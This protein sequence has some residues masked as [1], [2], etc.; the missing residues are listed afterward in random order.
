MV[1]FFGETEIEP[2]SPGTEMEAQEEEEEEEECEE[3]ISYEELKKRMWKDRLLLQKMQEKR[4]NEDPDHLSEARQEA[5]RRKKMSR[6][7]DAILKYMVKIMEVCKGKGFVY[8]IVPEKGKPI[9]GSSDSLRKWWK[10][11]VHFDKAAPLAVAEFMPEI[12]EGVLDPVSCMHLLHELQ[13]TT[14]GSLLSALMQHCMP[15]Q[16]RFPLDKGHAPPWWPTGNE[17]WWGEQGTAQQYGPPPYRKPHDLKKAWKVSVLAAVIKHMSP[18]L[19]KMRRLVR[20]SKCL[21]HKMTAKESETWSKVVNHEEA[22]SKLTE[23]C[24]KISAPEDGREENDSE[25]SHPAENRSHGKR[26]ASSGDKRKCAQNFE[27]YSSEL[28]QGFLNKSSRT[29]HESSCSYNSSAETSPESG[30]YDNNLIPYGHYSTLHPDNNQ[31]LLSVSDWPHMEETK[32]N[33]QQGNLQ[34]NEV[35]D[36]SSLTLQD[37]IDFSSDTIEDLLLPA[38]FLDQRGDMDWNMCPLLQEDMADQGVISIWDLGFE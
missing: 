37:Y 35:V 1:K 10:E 7:Q 20:Q 12:I 25:H 8:G 32:A 31:C 33:Y 26:I 24:L 4:V 16:R 38:E 17:I 28:G 34:M 9:T 27:N 18:N 11:T 6:A 22:L 3:D 2:P 21:Q 30:L 36:V 15:P 13:D 19:D 29:D 14:L 23:N 5:S